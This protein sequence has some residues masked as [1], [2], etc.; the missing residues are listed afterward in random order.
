MGCS[1]SL[2]CKCASRSI[3]NVDIARWEL[4]AGNICQPGIRAKFMQNPSVM[5]ILIQKTGL[6]T[7]VECASDR[8]WGTGIPLNDPMCLDPQKWISQGIMGQILEGICNEALQIQQQQQQHYSIVGSTG[9]SSTHTNNEK[10]PCMQS[11]PVAPM[12]TNA[13]TPNY[14]AAVT[15]LVS[16]QGQRSLPF[17]NNVQTCL[18]DENESGSASTTPV[19]DTTETT[20]SDAEPGEVNQ[21][22]SERQTSAM[23]ESD[24]LPSQH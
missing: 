2:E 23:E 8:L 18:A 3:R 21:C 11:Q 20:S 6:K 24:T 14:N 22:N 1:T 13:M 5:D 12:A 10:L 4:V 16:S 17:L 7:I 9:P 19:S 15:E